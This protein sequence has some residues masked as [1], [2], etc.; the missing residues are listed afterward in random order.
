MSSLKMAVFCQTLYTKDLRHRLNHFADDFKDYRIHEVTTSK[1]EC[2][3]HGLKLSPRSINNF[4]GAIRTLFTYAA[5]RHYLPTGHPGASE[6]E[7][8]TDPGKSIEIFTPSEM[9]R[10]FHNAR[11]E[12]I[13]FLALGAFGGIRS[14]EIQ[15][16]SWADVKWDQGI[17]EIASG[18]AKTR[19]RRLVPMNGCLRVW[20]QPHCQKTGAIVP[21]S[22]ADNQLTSLTEAVNADCMKENP[23]TSFKWKANAL[24]HSY[25]SYRLAKCENENQVAHECG[26][27]PAMIYKHYRALVSRTEADLWFGIRPVLAANIIPMTQAAAA[28]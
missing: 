14:A 15:R 20:L 1:T 9:T 19:A 26:N 5:A 22:N 16:L 13:P 24:R 17:I 18:K 27:S 10:I 23:L 21:F 28:S 3:L 7:K 25:A 11:P 12:I 2:W 8:M 6:L 4:M